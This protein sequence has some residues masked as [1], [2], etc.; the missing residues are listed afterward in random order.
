[1]MLN[2]I[3]IDVEEYFHASNIEDL[4]GR[5]IWA[6]LPSRVEYSTKKLLSLFSEYNVHATFFVLGYVARRHPELVKTIHALGH[7]VA[8]HGFRHRL[9]YNQSPRSFQRDVA[10]SK[11]LLED[12]IG[13]EIY[14][15]R[16]PNFSITSKTPWAYD[17]LLN[18]GYRYDSSVYPTW[19]PRYSNL[20]QPRW[21]Y[22]VERKG[23][24]LMIFPLAVAKV[25][26]MGYQMR[27]PVAG[28]AYWR[29]LP[30]SYLNWGL[31]RINSIDKF[32]ANCYL[33]PWEL[34]SEQPSFSGM[35]LLKK[36]RHYGGTKRLDKRL[37]FFLENFQFTTLKKLAEIED[38]DLYSSNLK[39]HNLND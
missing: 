32:P 27:L 13:T 22:K 20:S 19:H 7:E 12:I 10:Y 14:G 9:A 5:S 26:L 37:R 16:A 15:Y 25:K 24:H 34:D 2:S 35:G 4:T 1:M 21:A 38:T 28:G 3:S 18:A 39:V 36:L 23:Q 17:C 8:S 33:H 29:L 30:L 11:K 6:S 31:K